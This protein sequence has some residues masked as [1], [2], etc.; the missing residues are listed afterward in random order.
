MLR[1]IF[2]NKQIRHIFCYFFVTFKLLVVV[3]A[4]ELI[5]TTDIVLHVR[6]VWKLN[7]LESILLLKFNQP[8][9]SH[10][11]NSLT[12][13]DG[14]GTLR[15]PC[16]LSKLELHRYVLSKQKIIEFK[17]SLKLTIVDFSRASVSRSTAYRE[18]LSKRSSSFILGRRTSD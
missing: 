8:L 10:L 6:V 5:E 4:V 17:N 18:Q 11:T 13:L 16:I 2:S 1:S 15:Q 3:L 9:Q 12:C 14:H 7:G